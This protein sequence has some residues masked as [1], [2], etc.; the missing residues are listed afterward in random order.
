[1]TKETKAAK[2][3][4]LGREFKT[5]YGTQKDRLG[6]WQDL[7]DDVGVVAGRSITQCRKV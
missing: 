1:M 2:A 3:A 7:C 5:Y 4:R 6:G